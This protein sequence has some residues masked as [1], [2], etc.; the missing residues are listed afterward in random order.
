MHRLF[1]RLRGQATR[2]H[3]SGLLAREET[4]IGQ[5]VEML[6]DRRQGHRKGLG[7]FAHRLA[8]AREELRQQRAPGGIGERG[9]GAVQRLIAILNHEV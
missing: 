7:Q 1:H 5:D 2:H 3:P 4:R 6:H 9:K 8:V